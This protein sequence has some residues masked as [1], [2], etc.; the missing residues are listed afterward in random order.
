[1]ASEEERKWRGKAFD[2]LGKQY[3]KRLQAA[4]AVLVDG[5]GLFK[6]ISPDSNFSGSYSAVCRAFRELREKANLNI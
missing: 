1:M 4:Y 3:T 5:E 2:Y 6:A